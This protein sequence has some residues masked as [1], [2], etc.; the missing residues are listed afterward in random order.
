[1]LVVQRF[2]IIISVA[3]VA[4]HHVADEYSAAS[5]PGMG[6]GLR[7]LNVPLL[8]RHSSRVDLV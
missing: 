8:V 7:L 3:I 6:V 2:F 5:G 1:M 4:V